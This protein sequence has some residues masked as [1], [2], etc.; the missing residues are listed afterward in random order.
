MISTL[1]YITQDHLPLPH[2]AQAQLALQGGA[3]WVQFRS[4]ELNPSE[5]KKEALVIRE[6][7]KRYQAILILNDNWQLAIELDLDGVHVGLTDTPIKEIR[8]HSD[9]IIGGT[10]NTFEDIQLHRTSGAN[11]V[12]LG[13]YRHTK[14]KANLSPT[15]GIE[16]FKKII[17]NCKKRQLEIPI[18]AIGGIHLSDIPLLKSVGVHGIAIASQINQATSPV[19]STT[20]FIENLAK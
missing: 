18:I 2:A 20:Q 9:F 16:G 19:I 7:C 8:K 10:A 15:L 1:H 6:L 12:G 4:K 17:T 14:T 5:L 3:K 11:Y 13:P